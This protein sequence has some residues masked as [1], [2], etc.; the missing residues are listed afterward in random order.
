MSKILEQLKQAEAQRQRVVAERRQLEDE[1]NTALAAREKEELAAR[2]RRGETAAVDPIAQA[3]AD[4]EA[5][6]ASRLRQAE[7]ERTRAEAEARAAAEMDALRRAEERA[8]AESQARLAAESSAAADAEAARLAI[9][10][11][12]AE[13]RAGREE[14][15][16]KRAEERARTQATARVKAEQDA[17]PPVR[18][19]RRTL[20]AVAV[21]VGVALI[22]GFWPAAFPPEQAP[23]RKAAGVS[24]APPAPEPAERGGSLQLRFDQ[25]VD[26]FAARVRE[27]E[28][29]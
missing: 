24:M 23:P 13:A 28:R 12:Q 16:R 29:Q 19:H 20:A 3:K 4:A 27:K 21:A 6:A 7:A 26:A 17:A 5:L 14:S 10:R 2:A 8:A 1:A 18:K 9:A 15:E 11:R 25:D 22:A